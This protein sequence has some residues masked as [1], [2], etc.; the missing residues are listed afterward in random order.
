MT[1]QDLINQVSAQL[2]LPKTTVGKCLN[3]IQDSIANLPEG[4]SL[5]LRGFGTFKRTITPARNG[6]NPATGEKMI[7]AARET[8]RFQASKKLQKPL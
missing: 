6:H 3:S 5:T 7:I 2:D 4:D 8:L 1:V